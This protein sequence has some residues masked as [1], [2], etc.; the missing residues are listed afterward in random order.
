MGAISVCVLTIA[1]NDQ[2][3]RG[4]EHAKCLRV[5]ERSLGVGKTRRRH[6]EA[7]GAGFLCEEDEK[8]AQWRCF[9]TG[10]RSDTRRGPCVKYPVKTLM[11]CEKGAKR[12]Q[13]SKG[14]RREGYEVQ[15]ERK[16]QWRVRCHASRHAGGQGVKW[17]YVKCEGTGPVRLPKY[18][19][20]SLLGVKKLWHVL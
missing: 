18:N 7:V 3:P 17:T 8:W 6:G 11:A 13:R 9:M 10:W 20:D 19:W 14:R 12:R 1:R 4:E 15:A 5:W 2:E 16:D